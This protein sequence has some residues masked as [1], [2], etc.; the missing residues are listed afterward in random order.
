MIGETYG[1]DDVLQERMTYQEVF[2]SV[3]GHLL[4]KKQLWLSR[5]ISDLQLLRQYTAQLLKKPPF[6]EGRVKASEIVAKSNHVENDGKTL[7]RRI[8]ALFR[9]YRTFG[10][11]PAETRG[12]KRNGSSYLDNE[13]VFQACRAWLIAQEVGTVTPNNF[14]EAINSVILPRLMIST[15]RG[16]SRA[17]TY[18]WLRRLGFYKSES[19]KGVYIDGHER[20]DVVRYRQDVFLPK[21]KELDSYCTHYDE[22]EDGTWEAL[23]PDLPAGVKRHVF[24]FHDESC[25]HGYDYKKNIWLDKTT[26]QQ[27]MPGKSKGRLVHVSDFIGPEGRIRVDGKGEEYED[28]R[29]IIYPG[30]NGDPW[31]DTNQLLSQ[32]STVLKIFEKKH[33]DCIAV[34]VFDQS[35]AHAS[36]GEGALNAFGMNLTPGGKDKKPQNDTYYPP[37]CTI[38]ELRGQVQHLYNVLPDGTHQPKGIKQI[39]RERGCDIDNIKAKCTKPK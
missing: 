15:S 11:L 33:P 13:D 6:N 24:Y 34:L 14:H 26:K 9:H 37:E 8:R 32:L 19:K 20:E 27:K 16:I 10:G 25:F 30:S 1:D 5:I 38:P 22:K 2:D 31:W 23:L 7:A 12:G 21:M 39:L 36:H 17:T 18:R 35:S 3:Q 29:K 4:N 28:G